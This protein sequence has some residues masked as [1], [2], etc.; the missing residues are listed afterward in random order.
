MDEWVYGV[1]DRTEYP[2]NYIKTFGM[3]KF[4]DLK[5][6]DIMSSSVNYGF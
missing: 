1:A 5:A 4:L 2:G 6:R 3:Q